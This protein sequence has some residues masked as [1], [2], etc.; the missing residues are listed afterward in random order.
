ML[1]EQHLVDGNT[2]TYSKVVL[3]SVGGNYGNECLN[4]FQQDLVFFSCRCTTQP[5]SKMGIMYLHGYSYKWM[6]VS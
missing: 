4:I 3:G 5:K 1:L 6:M 2:R